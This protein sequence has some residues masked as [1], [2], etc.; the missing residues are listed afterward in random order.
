M[1]RIVLMALLTLALPLAAFAN[2]IDF[3]NHGG[4]ISGSS[5]GLT[6]IGSDLTYIDIYNGTKTSGDLGTVTFTTGALTAGNITT[7]ATFAAGGTFTI[8]GAGVA[9]VG[10]FSGPVTWAEVTTGT[11]GE[12]Y[13][14]LS[15]NVSGT[16]N[17]VSVSGYTGQLTFLAG[18]NGFMGGP[19]ALASGDTV[20]S[21]VP[22][23]GTLALLGT[24]MVGLAGVIRKRLKA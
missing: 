9:F 12:I 18:K 17:G 13:Y 22:E 21:S 16:Y 4:T 8:T 11:N 7:G 1:K 3:T 6:L 23:P 15:G 14:T 5:A 20:V 19:I 2:Q 24:G 10:T